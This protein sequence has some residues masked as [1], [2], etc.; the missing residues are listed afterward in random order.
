[1]AEGW[2]SDQWLKPTVKSKLVAFGCSSNIENPEQEKPKTN[3]KEIEVAQ[4][5]E[6]ANA[7]Y[8]IDLLPTSVAS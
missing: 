3:S 7:I 5:K 2:P 1:M 4:E 6:H 8:A